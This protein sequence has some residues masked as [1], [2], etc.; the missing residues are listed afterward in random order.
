MMSIT[1]EK[2]R[3]GGGA[4]MP[5]GRPNPAGGIEANDSNEDFFSVF[6]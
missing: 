4:G 1:E 6:I 2:E 5:S 3:S